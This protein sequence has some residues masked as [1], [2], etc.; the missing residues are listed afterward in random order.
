MKHKFSL[1]KELLDTDNVLSHVFFNCAYEHIEKIAGKNK[2]LTD[3]Q[4]NKRK[5]VIELK[6][7]GYDCDPKLFFN[8]LYSQYGMMVKKDAT[9]LV[10]EQTSD[11]LQLIVDKINQFSEIT[12]DFAKEISWDFDN[13]FVKT[14]K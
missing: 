6:I 11:K 13:T 12:D 3:E 10:K 8:K 1:Y 5:I 2:G 14:E 9:K 4:I 7:D